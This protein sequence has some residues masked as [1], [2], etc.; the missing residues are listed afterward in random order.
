MYSK[1]RPIHRI[2][3]VLWLSVLA[4]MIV[5]IAVSFILFFSGRLTSAV[6]QNSGQMDNYL[7]LFT[8]A[9]L[10]LIFY[11]KRTYLTP[12]SLV[13]RARKKKVA[14]GTGDIADLVETFGED[15]LVP[16]KV[17]IIMRRYFMLVWSIANLILL[18]GFTVAILTGNFQTFLIYAIVSLYTMSINFPSFTLIEACL[19]LIQ[20]ES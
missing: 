10:L 12:Q 9:L 2:N 4:G 8:I 5:L 19:S 18:L 6:V 7:M 1:I 13:A 16:A 3:R 14:F 11:L 20:S 15:S 17:L